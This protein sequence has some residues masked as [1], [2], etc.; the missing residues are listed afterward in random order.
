MNT[1]VR[2]PRVNRRYSLFFPRHRLDVAPDGQ[3]FLIITPQGTAAQTDDG[4]TGPAIMEP[5]VFTAGGQI[6]S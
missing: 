3:R 6:A 2:P 5:L 4:E 1:S